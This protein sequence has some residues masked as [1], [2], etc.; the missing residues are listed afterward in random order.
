MY[1]L[2]YMGTRVVLIGEH[3]IWPRDILH[4]DDTP[5]AMETLW[6]IACRRVQF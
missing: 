2:T 4:L 5:H 6:N 3:L 1:Q